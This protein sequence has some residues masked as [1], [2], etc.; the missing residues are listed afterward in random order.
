MNRRVRRMSGEL[1]EGVRAWRQIRPG[2]FGS[3]RAA[4]GRR[5]KRLAAGRA[6][7]DSLRSRPY[8]EL[9][10]ARVSRVR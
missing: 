3:L 6:A 1:A 9:G 4:G 8:R 5:V 10:F 7:V 2:G